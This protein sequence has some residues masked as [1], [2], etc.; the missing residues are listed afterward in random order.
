M[1]DYTIKRDYHQR[2]WITSDGG[3]LQYRPDRKSPTN[4]VAY[5]RISTLS[6]T[7]DDKS[8]LLDWAA[9]NAAVGVVRDP[10][11]FSQIAHLASAH[12]DPWLI[13][14]AKQQLKPLVKRAQQ[15]AGSEDAAGIGTALHG[16]TQLV[17]EG[18]EPEFVPPQLRPWIEKYREALEAWEVLDCEP[19]LVVDEIQGAGSMDRLLRHKVTGRIVCADI[20]T[21]RSDPDYPLKVTMQVAMYSRGQRYNQQTGQRRPLHPEVDLDHGLMIHVPVRTG[22]PRA[23]LYPLDL[24]EGWWLAKIAVQVRAARKMAKLA[25]V[26]A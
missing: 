26:A 14:E 1:T 8:G 4:A 17:D 11:I 20:K 15:I 12:R 16:L 13:P 24:T 18:R 10:G 19:F 23:T 5:T 21:G 2:P 22:E 25:A 3:P 7:L 9:C 6:E